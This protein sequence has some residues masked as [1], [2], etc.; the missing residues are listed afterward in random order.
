MLALTFITGCKPF[1]VEI[2]SQSNGSDYLNM[3]NKAPTIKEIA[4]AA[5]VSSMTVS[6]ALNRDTG[7]RE[8]TRKRIVKIAEKLNYRPNRIAR[9]L[10]SKRSNLI[11][12]IVPDIKN[13]FFAELARGIED[14]AR[15]YGIH[16]IFSSTDNKPANLNNYIRYMLEMGVDG[17]ILASVRLR[18]P[19]VTELVQQRFPVVLVSR[20]LAGAHVNYVVIDNFKGAYLI[21]EHLLKC[22]YRKIG[23]IMGSS[24]MSTGRDRMGGYRKA[25]A[26]YGLPLKKEYVYQ[27]TFARDTGYKGARRLLALKDRPDAIFAGSDYFALSVFDATCEAGIN[28]PEDMALAGFDDT[29]FSGHTRI[30]LTTVSQRK[31][32]MGRMGFQILIDLIE[33]DEKDYVNQIVLEPRLIIRDSCGYNR[34][35]NN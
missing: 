3:K 2:T 30:G 31:Y 8:E 14:K 5:D 13:Q 1:S 23:I 28:I 7:V 22:G 20:K 12:L 24:E 29:E 10:V 17:F 9:A 19:I 33:G 11:S 16:I 26:D 35:K 25:L 15:E 27:G 18:E 6:R 34:Q 21:T 4:K 32:E